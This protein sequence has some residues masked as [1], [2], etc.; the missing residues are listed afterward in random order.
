M[1]VIPI[2]GVEIY[3]RPALIESL[4]PQPSTEP[5]SLRDRSSVP[6]CDDRY[7]LRI[8]AVELS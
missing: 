4:S 7:D 3:V 5:V 6:R 8:P 1:S 2:F